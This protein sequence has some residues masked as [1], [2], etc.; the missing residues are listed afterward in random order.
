MEDQRIDRI[1]DKIEKLSDGLNELNVTLARNTTSLEEHMKQTAEVR[2][3]TELL[4]VYIDNV[5]DSL[6]LSINSHTKDDEAFHQE[7]RDSRLKI[8]MLLW[9]CG[10]LGT[11]VFALMKS[12]LMDRIIT[13]LYHLMG[14]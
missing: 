13:G 9:V 8:K 14:H 10:V 4:R 2:K 5:K 1:E 11:S 12:G 7:V 6:V 3:Q